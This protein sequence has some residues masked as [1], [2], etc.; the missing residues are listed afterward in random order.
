MS[1]TPPR[2]IGSNQDRKWREAI[3]RKLRSLEQGVTETSYA[4]QIDHA[5]ATITYIGE[6]EPGSATSAAV[7]R[8]RRV[9]TSSGTTVTWADGNQ[10]FDNIWDNRIGLTYS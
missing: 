3:T 6:A 1:L 10:N 2:E 9:D 4:L 8:I 5:S 7:W